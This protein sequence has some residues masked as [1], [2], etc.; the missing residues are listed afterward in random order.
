[1]L[2]FGS[3]SDVKEEVK[4]RI[5]ELGYDGGYLAAPAHDIQPEAPTENVL[6]LFEAVR[7]FGTYPVG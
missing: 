2:P 1:V 4:R 6:A 7:E 3:V 5:H